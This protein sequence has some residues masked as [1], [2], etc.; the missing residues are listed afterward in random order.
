M[1]TPKPTSM[2]ASHFPSFKHSLRVI[3]PRLNA[4]MVVWAVM[5]GREK[6]PRAVGSQRGHMQP[7]Q[8]RPNSQY[9]ERDIVARELDAGHASPN[10]R[11]GSGQEEP[12]YHPESPPVAPPSYARYSGFENRQLAQSRPSISRR[13]FRA[14]ARF[15]FTVLLGVGATL[16]WQSYGDKASVIVRAWDPSLSWLLPVSTTGSPL[17][18]TTLPELVE[19]LKPMSLDLAIV[20]RGLEQ[21]A[22]N[23]NQFVAKQEEIARNVATLQ[24][25][26]QEIKQ[27]VYAPSR[28]PLS[29]SGQPLR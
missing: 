25:V 15:L 22:A 2:F 14:V 6:T 3:R 21:L 9:R 28:K 18:A 5:G 1:A 7:S 13:I 17:A 19:Q 11:F 8:G 26:E 29:S 24:E 16:G 20:R 4:C 12:E 23:Q 27:A 10:R